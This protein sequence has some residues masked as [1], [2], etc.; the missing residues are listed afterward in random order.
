MS[1]TR[2]VTIGPRNWI[3]KD[4]ALTGY[5]TDRFQVCCI[6]R[7]VAVDIIR[8]H[9]YSQ[10]IVNNSYIHL[11]VYMAGNLM[12]ALQFGY[13]MNPASGKTI[14]TGT[15]NREYLE[16][17]RMWISDAVPRNGESTALSYAIRYIKRVYPQVGWIQSFADERCGGAGVVYQAA[18]FLYCGSHRTRF[19]ELDGEW[20]HEM[21]MNRTAGGGGRALH[22]QANRDRAVPHH[23]RQ[24]RYIY[25]IDRRRLPFLRLRVQPPPKP[26]AAH[27]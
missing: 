6:P 14:V 23:F 27:G 22:L 12:G 4:G 10:R 1:A 25:F 19:F 2:L 3:I 17:N 20:Y 13:A 15:G 21:M 16:L 5:G 8:R 7:S 26:G 9:H 18:N 24:F 11:G